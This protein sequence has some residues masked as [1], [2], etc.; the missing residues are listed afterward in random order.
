MKQVLYCDLEMTLI[1]SWE[2]FEFI[3]IS[4]PLLDRYDGLVNIFS[5]AVDNESDLQKIK[6]LLPHFENYFHRK[7]HANITVSEIADFLDMSLYQVKNRGKRQGFIDYITYFEDEPYENTTYILIDDLVEPETIKITDN[8]N[9][10]FL[11]PFREN[12]C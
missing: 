11:N 10:L 3:N 4:I 7:F 8:M 5:Y 6:S 9:I 2:E 12:T 1:N